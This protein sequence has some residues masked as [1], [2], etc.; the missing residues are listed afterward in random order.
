M[1]LLKSY[2][3]AKESRINLMT[4]IVFAADTINV[5]NNEIIAVEHCVGFFRESKK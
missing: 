4:S 1:L 2:S 3:R 5:S